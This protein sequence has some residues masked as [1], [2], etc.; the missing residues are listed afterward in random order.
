[1]DWAQQHLED[2][3]AVHIRGKDNL[4]ADN[5]SRGKWTQ[6]EWS[7]HPKVFCNLSR[8]FSQPNIDLMATKANAKIRTDH[9]RV[10]AILPYWP[11]RSWFSDLKALSLAFTVL[12][13]KDQFLT[14]DNTDVPIAGEEN[15]ERNW[16]SVA[17]PTSSERCPICLNFLTQDVGF[18]EN[19]YHA[20]CVT[21][22]LKWSE[23]SNSCPVDRKQFQVVYK[24]NPVDG[25]T[26]IH[27]KARRPRENCCECNGYSLSCA[28]TKIRYSA[29]SEDC[30][31]DL[32]QQKREGLKCLRPTVI[33]RKMA[34]HMSISSENETLVQPQSTF[35]LDEY[36]SPLSDFSI[37]SKGF[38]KRTCAQEGTEKKTASGASNSRGTR[39]KTVQSNTRRRSTRNSRSEDVHKLP[40]S[41]KSSNSDHDT[42]GCNSSSANVSS[43]DH[44]TKPSPKQRKKAPKKRSRVR[45]RLRSATQT[46]EESSE[47]KEN[48]ADESDQELE[49]KRKVS[50]ESD[51]PAAH[52]VDKVKR[53]D[54]PSPS[55]SPVD[56]HSEDDGSISQPVQTVQHSNDKPLHSPVSQNE[57]DMDKVSTSPVLKNKLNFKRGSLSP[58]QVSEN[59]SESEDNLP[60]SMLENSHLKSKGEDSSDFTKIRS[61]EG[62]NSSASPA[63]ERH[64]DSDHL[65]SPLF[66]SPRRKHEED[67]V[68][69]PVSIKQIKSDGEDMEKNANSVSIGLDSPVT[70]QGTALLKCE[71]Y[72]ESPV[73]L[74]ENKSEITEHTDVSDS[75]NGKHSPQAPSLE[76]SVMSLKTVET[77]L[78]PTVEKRTPPD[79]QALSASDSEEE[80]QQSKMKFVAAIESGSHQPETK[81]ADKQANGLSV[82]VQGTELKEGFE[83][84]VTTVPPEECSKGSPEMNTTAIHH[85]MSDLAKICSTDVVRD[86]D[87]NKV[88]GSPKSVDENTSSSKLAHVN[89]NNVSSVDANNEQLKV[90]CDEDNNE[91]VAMECESLDSDHNEPG[92]EQP[93]EINKSKVTESNPDICAKIEELKTQSSDSINMNDSKSNDK[94]KKESRMRKSRFHSPSTTWSPHKT[95]IKENPRSR[96]RSCSKGRDSP[97]KHKS[98]SHS[99]DRD[100][101]RDH[102]GQWKG[103]SRERR[104][105]RLS[106][107]KSR[108]RSRSPRTTM[109]NKGT[110]PDRNEADC[111][112]PP[113]KERRPYDNWKGQRGN[114]RYKRSEQDKANENFRSERHDVTRDPP[115]QYLENTDQNDYPDWVVEKMKSVESRGKGASRS[116]VSPRGSNWDS[117]H[118]SS[119]ESWSRSPDT[120]WKTPR[121][122]G[123]RGRGRGGFHGGFG[124]ADQNE[125]QWNNR[126]PFSGN[127]NSS[128]HES[129]R[130]TEQRN[131]RPKYDQDQFDSPADRSGWSSASSWAVRKTLP[132][133]VQNYYSKRGRA[134]TSSQQVWPR[135]EESQEQVLYIDQP[136]KDQASQPAESPQI[137]VNMIPPQMNVVQQQINPPPPQPMNMF[138]YS[139]SVPPPPLVNIQHNPYNIHPQLPMHIHPGLPLVQVSAPTSVSQVLPPPP[140]PPPP[141]QQVNYV[142]PQQEGK[143]PQGNP[144]ASHV[145]NN[146]SAPLLPA[147]TAAMGIVGSVLGSNSGSVASSSHS[148]T[149]HTSVKPPARKESITVEASADSSKKGK[150]L[151]IQERAAH[152]VK[153][154][155]KQY[156][157]NKDITKDEY[158]EIVRK[159]VDKVCHSKSGEVDSAKVANLVK[160]Y[161]D[162]YKHSRKK[163]SEEKL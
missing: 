44:S 110:P 14:K 137:S 72:L 78:S 92:I 77:Q 95:D 35:S 59:L 19:C 48:S 118:Y 117:N 76:N 127:S 43:A 136:V 113:W 16:T 85:S 41:P 105:R 42:P 142:A 74:D 80:Q 9:A 107:S 96:S 162:K 131:Y 40:S 106:R 34:C 4:I 149:L 93:T 121:G 152:E 97:T 30:E 50:S 156:Y 65:G 52:S 157:Q 91:S 155:I 63:S 32:I 13:H 134:P 88:E 18:P 83:E 38:S 133:D 140:P 22:I 82:N 26:K 33:T 102:S 1:M 139:V 3:S 135:P 161:V 56:M 84:K 68:Y 115:E 159:A 20:F 60:Q 79:L 128:G 104:H 153:M 148:K 116:R 64:H 114:Q 75:C 98:R 125:S 66:P 58:S 86:T 90:L 87:E 17:T 12:S 81:D 89:T 101:N 143:P 124:Y 130:F 29:V 150:K 163:G 21:C 108:S 119:G 158:K 62:E 24:I 15:K 151:Q 27:V 132:A 49:K 112:S 6:N 146:F 145:S 25:C 53:T 11:N 5:L 23:T 45:K 154:A 51:S 160:A 144:S 141:S 109:R 10:L 123:G 57:S 47:S 61:S 70:P 71:Q 37:R 39:K 28:K 54:S 67:P 147:P 55:M 7:L 111:S 99:R 138:P 2:I 73:S 94:S 100:G 103:R 36:V 120:D 129:S 46:Q 126:Q 69:S 8:K 122:R 31:I